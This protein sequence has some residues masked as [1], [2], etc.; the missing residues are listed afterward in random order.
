MENDAF[1]LLGIKE[2]TSSKG[3]SAI[4]MID[5]VQ[6]RLTKRNLQNIKSHSGLSYSTLANILSISTKTI[7]SYSPGDKFSES[8]SERLLKLAEVIAF[9]KKVF[10]KEDLFNDWLSKPLRPLDGKRPIDVM[11]NFYGLELIRNLL[12]RIEHSVYS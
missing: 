1:K 5:L 3:Q 8:A 10:G 12:G 11:V 4:Y 6:N 7:E 2:K 9:G